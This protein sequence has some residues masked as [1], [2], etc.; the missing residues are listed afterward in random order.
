MKKR[1]SI[2]GIVGLPPSYGGFET[3]TNYLTKY[4]KEFKITVYCESTINKLETYNGASLIY[5]PLKANGFQSIF[6]DSLSILKSWFNSDVILILGTPGF[7]IIPLL[8]FFKKTKT[9]VNFGGLEWKRE[10]WSY[11]AKVFLKFSER[12]AMKYSSIIV[13]DNK[14]FCKYI[15]DNYKK[16]SFLIEYGGDHSKLG[17]NKNKYLKS[18]SF[19]SEE[20]Y[21][22]VSRAQEDNNLHI[23]LRAFSQMPKNKL[24]LISNFD[25]SKYGR[26]LKKTYTKFENIFLVD[27]IYDSEIINTIRAC[28]KAYIHSHKYCGTAPSLVEI[29]NL[30]KPVFSYI[31]ETNYETTENKAFYFKSSDDLEHQIIN[32]DVSSLENNSNNMYKISQ[33]RYI[34]K[35][36]SKKYYNLL[37]N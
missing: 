24:V 16:K 15:Y 33:R 30:K 35:I 19:L 2:V 12:L 17:I 6:Y 1:V 28:C 18:Y 9:I 13:A 32:N 25:K 3:L 36:I 7:L 4:N 27:A 34:W 22:S 8:S 14:Y 37:A 26:N 29:M 21:L 11:L 10:K 23:V 31:S 20:Y 5:L